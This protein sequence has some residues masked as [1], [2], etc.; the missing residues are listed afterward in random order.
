MTF[1]FVN[2]WLVLLLIYLIAMLSLCV[3]VMGSVAVAVVAVVVVLVVCLSRSLFLFHV[4]NVAVLCFCCCVP[5]FFV[6]VMPFC[7]LVYVWFN[8]QCFRFGGACLF[9]FVVLRVL[10]V[11]LCSL[12]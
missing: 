11:C 6:R 7:F 8:L 4:C 3:P 10:G 12:R 1:P 2:Y 9:L 5:W